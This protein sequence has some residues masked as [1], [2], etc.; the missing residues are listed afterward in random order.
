M[1]KK[2]LKKAR[3]EEIKM[4]MEGTTLLPGSSDQTRPCTIEEVRSRYLNGPSASFLAT[5]ENFLSR[6]REGDLVEEYCSSK[7]SWR[8]GMGSAGYR[9][10]REG[11]QIAVLMVR[12]N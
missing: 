4:P 12:M 9:L 1:R 8:E 6:Y 5:V 2:K 3:A 7:Q 11:E 10:S